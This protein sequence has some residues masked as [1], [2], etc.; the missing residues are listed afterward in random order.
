MADL[1]PVSAL[2]SYVD[3]FS[4]RDA[5]AVINL[6]GD[7]SLA[8][9]P[10]LKPN[11]L[12]GKSEIRNGHAAVFETVARADFELSE[13]VKQDSF[14]IAEGKLTVQRVGGERNEHPVAVVAELG[15]ARL[16]RL[17]LYFNARHFRLWSDKTVL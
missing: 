1:S 10:L 5:E 9:I 11:R 6:F 14:A 13:P 4:A 12:F 17:T 16:H 8:E 2:Q 3:A 15:D 7:G